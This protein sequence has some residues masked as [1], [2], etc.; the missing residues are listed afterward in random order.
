MHEPFWLLC[1]C[2][3]SYTSLTI[4]VSVVG[5]SLL[6]HVVAIDDVMVSE[7]LGTTCFPRRYDG[8]EFHGL[9]STIPAVP[10]PVAKRTRTKRGDEQRNMNMKMT[11]K[12]GEKEKE[13]E[14]E[15]E[16]RTKKKKKNKKTTGK[17]L[18]RDM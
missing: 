12:D 18:E 1:I 3:L 5:L 4:I 8:R 16:Q 10:A 13:K 9:E 14:K 2:C 6:W 17:V 15:K 11:K 7:S